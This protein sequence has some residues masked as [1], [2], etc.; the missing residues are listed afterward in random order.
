MS[1]PDVAHFVESHI[2]DVGRDHEAAAQL[3]EGNDHD[4]TV[5]RAT[6]RSLRNVAKAR[7]DA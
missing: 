3:L 1:T 7:A 4:L 5:L 6:C 2:Q